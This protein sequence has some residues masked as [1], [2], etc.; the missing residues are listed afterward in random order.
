MLCFFI[1]NAG[2]GIMM[3]PDTNIDTRIDEILREVY[4]D[5]NTDIDL[6][7]GAPDDEYKAQIKQLIKEARIDEIHEF[8]SNTT[9]KLPNETWEAWSWRVIHYLQER[10]AALQGQPQPEE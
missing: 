9:E 7:N 3:T 8:T 2:K 1:H 4:Y 5:G 10:L 6:E